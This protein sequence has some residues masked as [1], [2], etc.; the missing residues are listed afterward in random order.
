MLYVRHLIWDVWNVDHIA[1][2]EVNTE[3]AEDVC[4]GDPVVQE[5]KKVRSLVFGPT[6]AGR[7]LTVVL[8]PTEATNVYYVVTARPAS[9]IE[10]AIYATEKQR[11]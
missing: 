8:D 3:K 7:L 1:R 2:H 11:G 5:G 4:H 10:R 6:R 9:R